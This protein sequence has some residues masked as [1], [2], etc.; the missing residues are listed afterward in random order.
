VIIRDATQIR[1]ARSIPTHAK[2]VSE[3][4]KDEALAIYD[5]RQSLMS[6]LPILLLLGKI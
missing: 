3:E 1:F 2:W 4:K 5:S 6:D